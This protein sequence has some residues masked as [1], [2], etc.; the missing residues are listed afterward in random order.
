MGTFLALDGAL[1]VFGTTFLWGRRIMQ[2]RLPADRTAYVVSMSIGALLGLAALLLGVEGLG[3]RAMAWFALGLG[4][5]F[6]G[7]VAS[8]AQ[9]SKTPAVAVG[10]PILDFTAPDENGEPFELSSMT[11]RPFLLKFFR[12]HW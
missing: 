10:G 6:V 4:A 1:I 7:L 5:T 3:A 2:V 11:G 12:G 8:S 9:D